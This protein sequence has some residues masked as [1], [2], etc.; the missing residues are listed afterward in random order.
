MVNSGDGSVAVFLGDGKG[1]LRRTGTLLTG[2]DPRAIAAGDLDGDKSL[3][4]L[5]VNAVSATVSI[6]I[7]DGRGGYPAALATSCG[8]DASPNA[9]HLADLDLDGRLDAVSCHESAK[10]L[11]VLRNDPKDASRVKQIEIRLG[12]YRAPTFI[13]SSQYW[14]TV[15][16]AVDG[17]L[18]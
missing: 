7:N 3:D 16:G 8:C 17:S 15:P 18:G 4:L 11:R 5:V 6:L 9:I 12:S 10:S 2:A 13:A 1:T 14:D